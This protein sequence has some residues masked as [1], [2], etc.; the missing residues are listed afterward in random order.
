MPK[1]ATVEAEGLMSVVPKGIR[2]MLV[3]RHI[4]GGGI[5]SNI[6]VKNMR[7]VLRRTVTKGMR[8]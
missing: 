7:T 3:I 2:C 4:T 1:D 8:S 6:A 5:F